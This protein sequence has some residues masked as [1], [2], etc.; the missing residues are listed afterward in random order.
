MIGFE[1]LADTWVELPIDQW[2][3][4]WR[5]TFQDPVVPLL[6]A[7][8]GHPLPG[9]FWERYGGSV[10]FDKSGWDSVPGWETHV[11]SLPASAGPICLRR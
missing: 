10:L 6:L 1:G 7:L 3:S 9:T 11:L 5:G 2:P 8:C 4:H